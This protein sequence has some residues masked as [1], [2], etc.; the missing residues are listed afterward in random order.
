MANQPANALRASAGVRTKP[1]RGQRRWLAGVGFSSP[2]LIGLVVF[3]AGPII[4]SLYYSFTD[5]NLFQSPRWVGLGN[6]RALF[7]DDRFHQAVWN[8][9]YLAAIGVPLGLALALL[10][11]LALNFPVRGQPLYR[12]IV[13]LP[14]IVPIVTATYLWRWILNAQY[15]YLNRM[16]GWLHIP[17]PDWLDDPVWTK[18]SVI[19]ITLWG[20]GSMAV[21]YLA[22]LQQVPQQQ[23]E[24]AAVDG[25]N[26][27]QRFWNVTWPALTPVTLFQ[28]IMGIILSLQIFTQPYLLVQSKLNPASGGPGN[29]LLTYSMYL[30]QNAFVYLKMGYAS[31]MAWIL[32]IVIGALTAIVLVT[33]KHWVHYG[34]E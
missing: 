3:T 30:Y 20:L 14:A 25:A 12:A 21:I 11:A 32:F 10:V 2:W 16:L 4:A 7:S 24:A 22:A 27:W 26:G 23:Y 34:T 13:Y 15:G 29:S 17:Q 31:A 6:Y 33:S 9:F 5:F 18:P 19:L 8:T 1:R 28:L